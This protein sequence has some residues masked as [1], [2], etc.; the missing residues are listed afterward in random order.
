MCAGA[1]LF[2]IDV[3][4]CF[5]SHPVFHQRLNLLTA[6][7]IIQYSKRK[8]EKRGKAKKSRI[9]EFFTWHEK[10]YKTIFPLTKINRPQRR[11][12]F[13]SKLTFSE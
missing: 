13:V 2:A 9:K 8:V 1:I 5:H 10:R 4:P 3:F 7:L 11:H 6:Q 12:F